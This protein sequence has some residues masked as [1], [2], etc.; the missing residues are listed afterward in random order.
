VRWVARYQQEPKMTPQT[1]KQGTSNRKSH[2][3]VHPTIEFLVI[4]ETTFFSQCSFDWATGP[5]FVP[6]TAKPTR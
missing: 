2:L 4:Y 6:P 5:F 1:R 3:L